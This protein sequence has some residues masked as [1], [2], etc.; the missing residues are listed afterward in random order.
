MCCS[1]ICAKGHDRPF[2]IT[3]VRVR[4]D[5]PPEAYINYFEWLSD[6]V[7]DT[8]EIE[9]SMR[10][11]VAEYLAT[12]EGKEYNKSI[13]YDFNW[14]DAIQEI[15]DSIWEKFN[16]RLLPFTKT[17]EICVNQDELLSNSV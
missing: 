8:R 12:P 7:P 5:N 14:G 13:R 15:P 3:L 9:R 11:A 16:L 4:Y 2:I 17:A 1:D 10:D 6:G